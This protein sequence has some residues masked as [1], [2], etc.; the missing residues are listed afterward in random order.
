ML[1]FHVLQ[2]LPQCNS[3]LQSKLLDLSHDTVRDTWNTYEGWTTGEVLCYF[4]IATHHLSWKQADLHLFND[5]MQQKK[6]W[7]LHLAYRQSIIDWTTSN[8]ALMEKLM[9][10]VSTR[11]WY[12]GPSWVLYWKNRHDGYFVLGGEKKEKYIQCSLSKTLHLTLD[13]FYQLTLLF[14]SAPKDLSSFSLGVWHDPFL[15]YAA[16]NKLVLVLSC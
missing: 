1:H 6:L 13:V 7:Y 8:L 5:A 11:I 16:R 9:K 3:V 4:S 2:F 10:L 12:G 15:S 14:L